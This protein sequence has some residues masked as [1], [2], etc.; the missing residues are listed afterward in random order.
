MT[1]KTFR[2]SGLKGFYNGMGVVCLIGGPASALFFWS[3]ELSK[4]LI[5]TATNLKNQMAINFISA[6]I[7]EGISCL[8]W[9]PI[10]VIK[11]RLQV[12]DEVKTYKYKNSLDA[13]T[14]I[15]RSESY[16]S[17]YRA[18][19]ATIVAFGPFI[20]I[21]MMTYEKLKE[22]FKKE[23]V[24]ITF[25]QSFMMAFISG[26]LASVVTSPLDIARLRM[27]I[28]RNQNTVHFMDDQSHHAYKS[29]LEGIYKIA[30]RESFLALWR[31]CFARIIHMSAQAAINLSLLEKVR[32][33]LIET[34]YYENR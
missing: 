15:I 30:K 4:R 8:L 34:F 18:Y 12:Q 31:G 29:V 6:N 23:K 24:P 27:Q 14:S 25:V 28:Q 5:E 11:E 1:A 22:Y 9:V 10:D 13:I 33:Q 17:L 21:N 19:G 3:Y 32:K 16:M 26:I 2:E 20:G 7:A